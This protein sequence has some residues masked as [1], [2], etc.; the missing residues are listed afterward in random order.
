MY[1]SELNI[2]DKYGI[3]DNHK[4]HFSAR[5]LL[6]RFWLDNQ[7]DHFKKRCFY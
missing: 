6:F 4:M 7:K 2:F 3:R 1:W 5:F